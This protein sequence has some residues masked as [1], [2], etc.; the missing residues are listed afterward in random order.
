MLAQKMISERK[1]VC[2]EGGDE[3]SSVSDHFKTINLWAWIRSVKIASKAP[4]C[5]NREK[6]R[7]KVVCGGGQN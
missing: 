2:R 5:T 3:S 6:M 1:K 4:V 7:G